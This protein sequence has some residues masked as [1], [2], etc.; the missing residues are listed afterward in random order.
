[1]LVESGCSVEKFQTYDYMND[2]RDLQ[3]IF[4][5]HSDAIFKEYS[6]ASKISELDV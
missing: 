4:D 2:L 3:R 5:F 6:N 1:L